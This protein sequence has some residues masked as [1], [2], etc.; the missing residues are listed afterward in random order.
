MLEV[1]EGVQYLHSG[2]LVH[3]DLHGVSKLE[4]VPSRSVKQVDYVIFQG[5]VLLDSEFHCLITDFGTI[6]HSDSTPTRATTIY[7][8]FAAPELFGTCTAC[9]LPDCDDE[10]H[11]VNVQ[12]K[13]ME[14]DIFAFGGVY[15]SVRLTFFL[16]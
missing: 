4:F 15:Y 7:V 5:N 13:T 1:A 6:Q 3:G 9:G 10:R 14:T 11:G 8:H 16:N 12:N 2:G